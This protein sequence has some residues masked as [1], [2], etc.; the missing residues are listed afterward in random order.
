MTNAMVAQAAAHHSFTCPNGTSA[1]ILSAFFAPK[2]H[3]HYCGLHRVIL[4]IVF[5]AFINCSLLRSSELNL[6][7][8]PVSYAGSTH[9]WAYCWETAIFLAND[10]AYAGPTGGHRL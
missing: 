6:V 8:E 2:R 5:W 4:V 7:A 1:L 3:H 9:S 10:F